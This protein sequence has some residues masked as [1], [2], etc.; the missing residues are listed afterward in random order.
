MS[1]NRDK[2]YIPVSIRISLEESP[3]WGRILAIN[4]DKIEI[5]SQFKFK[6]GKMTALGFELDGEK[7]E[8]IRGAV[9]GAIKDSCG[10]FHYI[11]K[12]TDHNQQ[13]TLLAKLLNLTARS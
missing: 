1:P 8:D 2:E 13:K 7:L 9:S 4:S 11:I 10:Y 6:Q 5:M 12:L 3:F